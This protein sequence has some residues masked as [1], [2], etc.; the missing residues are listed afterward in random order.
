MSRQGKVYLVGAGPGRRE[1]LTLRAYHL[2]CQAEV[3][4]YDA[5]VAPEL[6]QL[7]PPHCLKRGVGKR[8]GSP[9]PRQAAINRLLVDYCQQGRQVVRLKSGDP[10]IF[11]RAS[12]EMQA[13]RE[14]GCEFEIVAGI[15]SALAA[16]LAAGIPLTDRELS[17]CFAVLS[18]HDP[19]ALDWPALV[20]LDTLVILMGGRQLAAIVRHLQAGGRSPSTP[21]AII[22]NGGRPEQQVWVGTLADIVDRV[23]GLFLPPAVI[24]VGEAVKLRQMSPPP[25]LPLSGQTILVTRSA[26]QSSQF[27]Q[28]LERLGATVVEMPALEI[29]P[30]SSWESLDGA[31]ARLRDFHWL[32]LTSANGVEAFFNRLAASGRDARALADLA[33]AVVGRKT[34]ACLQQYHLQ[35][36]FI[37]PDFVADALVDHFPESLSGKKILFPRVETGGRETIVRELRARGAEVV[38]VAAYQSSCPESLSPPAWNALQEGQVDT[39]TFASSKTVQNFT[40]LLEQALGAHAEATPQSLLEKVCLA[41]IGPQT[42]QTCRD[43][44]GRVDVEAREYTLEGLAEALVARQKRMA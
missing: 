34:A 33:I 2:L 26:D 43:L 16:P 20:P 37:P 12:S 29:G 28:L 10:L 5:L 42:S 25:S 24:V 11:G 35:P 15:S 13:L 9:S 18:A 22:K 6:L 41:S 39:V 23:A 32:I 38:A 19:E 8:G 7:A 27:T 21:I 31:I 30:P 44:L 17:R 14:A 40:R 4:I 3:L 36:D 1:D